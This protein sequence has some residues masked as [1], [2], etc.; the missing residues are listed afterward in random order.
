MYWNLF[1]TTLYEECFPQ[2]LTTGGVGGCGLDVVNVHVKAFHANLNT[3]QNIL[4]NFSKWPILLKGS[5]ETLC[6]SIHVY[7]F[8]NCYEY[9]F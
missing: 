5:G 6:M 2:G 3:H 1:I 4:I 8:E 9:K 7:N